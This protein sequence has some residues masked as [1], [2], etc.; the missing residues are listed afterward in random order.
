VSQLGNRR[1]PK[2]TLTRRTIGEAVL[3]VGFADASLSAVGAHLG[4]AHSTLY[5]YVDDVADLVTAG[6]EVIAARADP[7]PTGPDWRTV[8]E[9]AFWSQWELCTAHPGLAATLTRHPRAARPLF[10]RGDD[11][12]RAL[13]ALGFDAELAVLV[14]DTLL[15]VVRDAV[16]MSAR[17]S[18]DP[19]VIRAALARRLPDP[20]DAA[21]R[22]V[23]EKALTEDPRWWLGR[24]LDLVLAGTAALA[25]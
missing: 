24:K 18:D 9:A 6:V 1:G 10:A 25:S 17:V 15:D 14:A 16:A 22:A 21:A 23:V 19:D 13:V 7:Q 2:P 12:G 4:V 5:R 20:A 8:C 3:A 11:L